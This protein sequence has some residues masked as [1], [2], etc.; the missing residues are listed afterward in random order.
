M[1]LSLRKSL[2]ISFSQNYSVLLLQFIASLIIARLLTPHELGIFSVSFV[3][4]GMGNT[5]RDFGVVEYIVQ[6]K[7]LTEQ[8]IRSASMLT[9]VTAWSIALAAWLLSGPVA[10]FYGEPDVAWVM[11]ILATNFLLVP[12]GSVVMAYL[13]RQMEFARIAR[14]RLAGAVTQSTL[15]V[16]LAYFGLSYF[17]MA[18]A[19][20]AASALNIGLTQLARPKGFPF[21]PRVGEMRRI[22]T[23]GSFSSLRVLTQDVDKGSPDLLLG[24]LMNM[25]AVAFFG[26][27]TSLIDLFHR[28]VV[29]AIN[30][31]ALPHLSARVRAGESL[32][33]PFLQSVRHITG[34]AWPFYAFLSCF[35]WILVPLLYGH[36]WDRAIALV[37]I[38]CV[39][40][41]VL[42]PFYLQEQLFIAHGLVRREAL[43]TLLAAA[44]KL[45][46]LILLAPYG[47]TWVAV[48]VA[49]STL[50]VSGISFA[51]LKKLLGLGLRDLIGAC[52]R[53]FGVLIIS[54][55]S[56]GI[57]AWWLSTM[58]RSAWVDLPVACIGFGIA[59]LAAVFAT[60]HPLGDELGKMAQPVIARLYRK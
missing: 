29:Q 8:R 59:W 26:R 27:A 56:S 31:V 23:F 32:T 51:M 45:V 19:A 28:L 40:E 15:A 35:A 57:S 7:D 47:L 2:L 38:L 50:L 22:F 17:S 48:G 6:E 4:I 16:V 54:A 34:V 46:P 52:G 21:W 37:Q 53:S 25:E 12:F 13:R 44:I 58:P 36:Q 24:R 55:I 11:R 9:F 60:R 49:A 1:S 43:R 33:E 10:A 14:I 5:L 3:L 39:G 42:A 41:I 18:I 30:H 20:V